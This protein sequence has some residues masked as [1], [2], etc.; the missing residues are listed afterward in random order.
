MIVSGGMIGYYLAKILCDSKIRVK[1]IEKD[2][3]T[4]EKM[5]F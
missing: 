2:E 4:C 5:Q 1:I 3:K